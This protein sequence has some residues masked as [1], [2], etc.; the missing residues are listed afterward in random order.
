[1][2]LNT[3][4]DSSGS[5]HVQPAFPS[6]TAV[7]VGN[8]DLVNK[9]NDEFIMYA[10]IRVPGMCAY[11]TYK[12]NGDTDGTYVVVNDGGAGFRPAWIMIKNITSNGNWFIY[13]DKRNPFNVVNDYLI[14]DDNAAAATSGPVQLDFTAN[15][16]KLRSTNDGTNGGSDTY[17]YLSMAE[18]P[19]GGD[20]V[21]QAKGRP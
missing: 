4:D 15:G 18:N 19:F 21:A 9:A 13:D 7:K 6:S 5:L 20:G 10:W 3:N 14:A 12:G 1:M 17:M 16:F 11:G 2:N 8:D